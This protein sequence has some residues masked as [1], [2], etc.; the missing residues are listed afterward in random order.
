M[1]GIGGTP[2]NSRAYT[3]IRKMNYFGGE[4]RPHQA[5]PEAY[6]PTLLWMGIWPNV[7]CV[8]TTVLEKRNVVTDWLTRSQP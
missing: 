3:V 8:K 5:S 1:P 2:L 6:N 7:D 4:G